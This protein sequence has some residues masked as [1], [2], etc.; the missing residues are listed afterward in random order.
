[1]ADAP[2]QPL[3]FDLL[4]CL[5]CGRRIANLPVPLPDIGDDFDWRARDYDALRVFMLEE[6]IARFPERIRRPTRCHKRRA[7]R[8]E[9]PQRT[10][11]FGP[12]QALDC[13]PF[14]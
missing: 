7:S 5:H 14:R 13:A 10:D 4:A 9:T 1:M 2:T 12:K 8:D 11:A 6:L 3:K